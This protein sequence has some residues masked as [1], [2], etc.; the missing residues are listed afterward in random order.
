M[1]NGVALRP[2][3]A[4]IAKTPMMLLFFILLGGLLGGVLGEIFAVISP[5]GPL[6]E[7]FLQGYTLGVVPPFTVDLRLVSLTAGFSLRFN[8][9][10]ILGIILGLYLHK[11]V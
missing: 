2:A 9:F 3:V 1:G 11:Q 8:L 6:R 10:S 5:V 4:Q 7:I